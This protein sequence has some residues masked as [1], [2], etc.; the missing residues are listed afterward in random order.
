FP[1]SIPTQTTFGEDI[2][3]RTVPTRQGAGHD[4]FR[5]AGAI[6]RRGINPVDSQFQ[7]AMNRRDGRVVILITPCELPT[8]AANGP[9]PEAHRRDE[10]IR[11]S[12]SLRLHLTAS[13]CLPD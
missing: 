8:G 7:C 1:L 3:T 12:K 5:V 9:S 2:R 4:F 6:D 10:Q 11:D 13:R